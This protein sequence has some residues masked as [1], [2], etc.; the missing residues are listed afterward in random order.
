MTPHFEQ[1][2]LRF[3]SGRVLIIYRPNILFYGIVTSSKLVIY[4]K[5]YTAEIIHRSVYLGKIISL[6][7]TIRKRAFRYSP[8]ALINIFFKN[9]SH[10]GNFFVPPDILRTHQFFGDL[11]VVADMKK[12]I[13][14]M[15]NTRLTFSQ[16]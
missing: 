14:D 11:K 6:G 2:K 7:Y 1:R 8:K 15:R 5:C 12:Y 13:D 3:D 4:A 10:M 16:R 9:L